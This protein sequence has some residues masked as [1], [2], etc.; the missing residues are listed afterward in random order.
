ML[1]WP[2]QA[3]SMPLFVKQT[4][5]PLASTVA[6][7]KAFFVEVAHGKASSFEYGFGAPP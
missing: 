7:A 4:V 1:C 6:G 2:L 5:P 3:I